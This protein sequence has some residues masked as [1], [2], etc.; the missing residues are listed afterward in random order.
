M[1]LLSQPPSAF[2]TVP[3]QGSL[4]AG[5]GWASRGTPRAAELLA[6]VV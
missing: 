3:C 4:G 1:Y 2:V 6:H 5:L